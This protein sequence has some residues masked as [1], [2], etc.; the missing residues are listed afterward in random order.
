M[1][2]T[3]V[4]ENPPTPDSRVPGSNPD[5]EVEIG[6]TTSRKRRRVV[7]TAQQDDNNDTPTFFQSFTG[8]SYNGTWI[9]LNCPSNRLMSNCEARVMFGDLYW[10]QFRPTI[11]KTVQ[12][13]TGA[14]R[15]RT[16]LTCTAVNGEMLY[17]RD[18]VHY[19]VLTARPIL[20]RGLMLLVNE[21]YP[22]MYTPPDKPLISSY[23][24]GIPRDFL[25]EHQLK[26]N[27]PC[28]RQLIGNVDNS[29]NH[30][31]GKCLACRD[32]HRAPQRLERDHK[33]FH[34]RVEGL[35]EH[36]PELRARDTAMKWAYLARRLACGL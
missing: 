3:S 6:P 16:L 20:W 35:R 14:L 15:V 18:H 7:F 25:E 22:G 12:E 10:L 19:S 2:M 29:C 26:N 5:P 9:Q 21:K 11:K 31:L 24:F 36:L 33:T 32:R 30:W 17:M 13:A 34:E 28:T 4:V 8:M 27:F 1:I 23:K